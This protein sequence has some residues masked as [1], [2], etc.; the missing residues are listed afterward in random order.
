VEER[1]V[2]RKA[3]REQIVWGAASIHK[4]YRL[5]RDS[6]VP[7]AVDDKL[8]RGRDLSFNRRKR[9]TTPSGAFEFEPAR[10]G[11]LCCEFACMLYLDISQHSEERI[12][13]KR[14]TSGGHPYTAEER[15]MIAP[16]RIVYHY[17]GETANVMAD[18]RYECYTCGR[19]GHGRMEHAGSLAF[20]RPLQDQAFSSQLSRVSKQK[21]HHSPRRGI[22]SSPY[23]LAS[24]D[25]ALPAW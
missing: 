12:N 17:H 18:F 11:L 1:V 9:D 24:V 7:R 14:Y 2:S 25:S 19:S 4:E 21:Q 13:H 8:H 6:F 16:S 20:C 10:Q 5:L 23:H 15:Y 3:A 22:P